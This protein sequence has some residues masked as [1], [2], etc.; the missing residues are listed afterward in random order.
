MRNF[1]LM[2]SGFLVCLLCEPAN[3]VSFSVGLPPGAAFSDLAAL[4][5][6]YGLPSPSTLT[7]EDFD[8]AT[9]VPGL[10]IT[11]TGGAGNFVLQTGSSAGISTRTA[12]RPGS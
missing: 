2:L 4:N 5:T 9:L 12:L 6:N 8:D 3:A 11:S 7:V 10:V 1:C